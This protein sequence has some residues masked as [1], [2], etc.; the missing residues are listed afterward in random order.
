MVPHRYIFSKPFHRSMDGRLMMMYPFIISVPHGGTMIPDEVSDR[1]A[2]SSAEVTFY[3][4]PGTREI[5]NFRSRGVS[6]IDTDIS[7]W[8]ISRSGSESHFPC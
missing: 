8:K 6:F 1:I 2:L 3:S 5:Y 4:D 7:L